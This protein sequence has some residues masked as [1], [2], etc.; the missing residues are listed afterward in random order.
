MK[1][2]VNN[3]PIQT[4]ATMDS[5]NNENVL[6]W[7]KSIE[8]GRISSPVFT[9]M[10]YSKV[11]DNI[12]SDSKLIEA[13]GGIVFNPHQEF[14]LIFRRGYWDLP[15]GKIDKG[16]TPELT[17]IRE[18]WEECGLTDLKITGNLEPS[19]HTYWLKG[20]RILKKSYWFE[21]KIPDFQLP[22]L[23][24]EEDIED[25]VWITKKNFT[26]YR[27]LTYPSVVDVIESHTS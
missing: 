7:V 18:V 21:M 19:F 13:A 25:S 26:P 20:K 15:K 4:N 6:E 23:Q 3:I 1:I 27:P 16:E 22:I 5:F 24:T 12:L 14:L 17:A 2:Y 9:Q 11:I 8:E 10:D